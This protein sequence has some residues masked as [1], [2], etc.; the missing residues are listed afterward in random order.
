ML[1][2]IVSTT[3]LFALPNKKE[4]MN[5]MLKL[6]SDEGLDLS[7]TKHKIHLYFDNDNSCYIFTQE[8][9]E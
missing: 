7:S 5:Y 1:R 4:Y 2:V 6:I 9:E 8:K 3:E